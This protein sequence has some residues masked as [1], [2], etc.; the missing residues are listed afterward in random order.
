M[1]PKT[2]LVTFLGIWI[3]FIAEVAGVYLFFIHFKNCKMNLISG[4][5]LKFNVWPPDLVLVMDDW[6]LHELQLLCICVHTLPV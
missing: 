5:F 1:I 2:D 4:L 6:T 3:T